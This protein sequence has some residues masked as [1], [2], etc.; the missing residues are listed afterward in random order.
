MPVKLSYEEISDK[1]HNLEESH[2]IKRVPVVVILE[3]IRSLYNVGS[4]FRTSD[5]VAVEKIYLTGFTGQPPRK[6]IDKTAL[7]AVESVPWE[8]REDN[9]ALI[10]ELK[11]GGYKIAV[12]EHCHESKDIFHYKWEGKIAIILGNEV[13]GVT[14]EIAAKADVALEIPMFGVKQSLNVSV[15]YGISVYALING[16]KK[17]D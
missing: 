5:A 1:R 10:D 14:D 17:Q 4:I 16:N 15:A 3:N 7:G 13:F 12:L 8:Y 2:K 11:Q 6:E 9:L